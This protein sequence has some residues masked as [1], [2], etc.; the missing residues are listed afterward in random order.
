MTAPIPGDNTP[1]PSRHDAL[2]RDIRDLVI[3][4]TLAPGERVPE[5][6]L[7]ERFG[8]S[9]TPLREAIKALASERILEL[10]PHRG[11]WV[12]KITA[13]EIDELF[14]VMGA[15][16]ALSGELAA[17]NATEPDIAE[18]KA[19]HYQMVLHFTRRELMDYFRLNQR[20]HE[21]IL[22]IAGNGTLES[23]Y[24]TLAFRIRRARYIANISEARWASAVAEHEE[25]LTALEARDGAR[26]GQLL[27]RHLANTCETVR[28]AIAET[29]PDH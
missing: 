28:K 12:T 22:A 19:L 21:K 2:V 4:G 26:L 24:R 5:R 11:A 20:I 18:V 14:Q 27:R 15:L 9:R 7:S 29:P 8:V 17:A 10:L 16:E 23:I 6:M 3:D 1:T 25:I 13:E